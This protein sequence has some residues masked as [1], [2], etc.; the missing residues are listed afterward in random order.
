M[1]VSWLREGRVM[2]GSCAGAR[3][4]RTS[5]KSVAKISPSGVVAETAWPRPTRRVLTRP[6]KGARILA[7]SRL[8][9]AW[10]RLA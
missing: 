10:S 5:A 7:R 3:G 8:R 6:S 2:K 9:E 1:G 4:R